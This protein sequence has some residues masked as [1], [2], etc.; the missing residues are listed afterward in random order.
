MIDK[1]EIIECKSYQR[2]CDFL[3]DAPDLDDIPPTGVVHVPL[4]HIE[5]FFKRIEGNGHNYVVVSSCS[6]FGL[7][8][9]AENPVWKDMTKWLC[10]MV[11]PALG[12]NGLGIQPP[13]CDRDKCKLDDAY[14]VKCHAYTRATFPTI[15]E[16]VVHWFVVNLM[17]KDER[18]TAIPFGIAEGKTD[19]LL[20]VMSEM[21]IDGDRELSTYVSWQ[22]YTLE[23]YQLREWLRG[24]ESVTIVEPNEAQSYKEYLRNLGTHMYVVSPPGNGADCY[25]TLEA[26]YMGA[27]VLCEDTVTNRLLTMPVENYGSFAGILDVIDYKSQFTLNVKNC[28]VVTRNIKLSYWKQAI[29]DQ[30]KKLF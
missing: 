4:D 26:L 3:Y 9:Q 14:S 28:P 17:V 2:L 24:F 15:P 25:R 27:T 19:E 23:R 30:R 8:L 5:E 7:A 16:N 22:D 20:E 29:D 6:D 13:R 10:M 1:S 21:N 18:C 11:G 12:Y